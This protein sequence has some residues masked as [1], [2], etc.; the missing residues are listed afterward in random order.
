MRLYLNDD[1]K[2]EIEINLSRMQQHYLKNVMRVKREGEVLVFNGRDGE[3]LANFKDGSL[4]IIKQIRLQKFLPKLKIAYAPIKS[5]RNDFLLEKLCE[6]GVTDFYP[7][8]TERTIIRKINEEKISIKMIE[9]AEQCER[10]ELPTVHPI[11]YLENF[12]KN[13]R[14]G[15]IFVGDERKAKMDLRDIQFAENDVFIIGPEGGFNDKERNLFDA[16]KV[17]R[18]RLGNLILR[19]ETAAIA[20]TSFLKFR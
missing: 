6:L 7:I 12:L 20:V 11:E 4:K 9:A 10:L 18:V 19:A 17:E 16:Y 1:L 5:D 13:W 3:W 15:K 2:A 14:G 8:I